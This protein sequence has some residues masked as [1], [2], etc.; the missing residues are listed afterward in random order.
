MM[1]TLT[2]LATGWGMVGCGEQVE[3]FGEGALALNWEVSPMGCALSEVAYVEVELANERRSYQEQYHCGAGE[4]A[5]EGLAPGSY[6]LKLRGY[7]PGGAAT[8]ESEGRQ[9]TVRPERVESLDVVA[10]KARPAELAVAW[11]FDNGRVCGANGV[12]KVEVTLYDLAFYEIAS[13]RFG[14]NRGEGTIGELYAGD[15]IVRVSATGAEDA[16]FQGDVRVSLK[17]G[18]RAQTEAVLGSP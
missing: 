18:E 17:R 16:R 9:V 14:C 6:E 10:L 12:D 11:R 13:Q 8:F 4:A 3:P 2:T 15:Y 5:L 7:D 1:M